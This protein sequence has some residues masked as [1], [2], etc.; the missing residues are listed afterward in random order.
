MKT[1]LK[2]FEKKFGF[3]AYNEI[4][5]EFGKMAQRIEEL[6]QS[7]NKWKNKYLALKEKQK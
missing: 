3:D 4:L 2:K 6:K 5:K 1:W 7:R